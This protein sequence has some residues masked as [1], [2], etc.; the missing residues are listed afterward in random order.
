M[1]GIFIAFEGGDGCGKSTQIDLLERHLKARGEAVLVT[2]E[3]GGC[4]I[5]EQ[6]RDMLLDQQNVEMLPATEALL[7]AASRAQHVREVL[8]PALAAGKIVLCDRY[9]LSSLAYQGYGRGL[10]EAAVLELNRLALDGLSPDLT[11]YLALDAAAARLRVQNRG[12][13]DRL[14][15]ED[16]AFHDRV[17]KG[18]A[19]L[20]QRDDPRLCVVDCSADAATIFAQVRRRVQQLLRELRP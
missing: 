12:G 3:P 20:A 17:R 5:A 11:F 16:A 10:G 14:E 4:P 1:R 18:F 9:I 19:T 13:T 15:G 2:R 6:I 7:Y 8:R